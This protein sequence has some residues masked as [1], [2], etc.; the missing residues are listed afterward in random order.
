MGVEIASTLA[1]LHHPTA[2]EPTEYVLVIAAPSYRLGVRTFLSTVK[3]SKYCCARNL[4]Y[5]Q[6]RFAWALDILTC[7]CVSILVRSFESAGFHENYSAPDTRRNVPFASRVA[8]KRLTGAMLRSSSKTPGALHVEETADDF[9]MPMDGWR[10]QSCLVATV[11]A[12]MRHQSGKARNVASTFFAR[13]VPE[14][15]GRGGGNVRLIE[16]FDEHFLTPP[17]AICRTTTFGDSRGHD[18]KEFDL[19]IALGARR[20]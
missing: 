6:D 17:R 9:F 7:T 4:S 3:P 11:P 12:E 20:R 16:A 8:H 14:F 18:P 5:Q 10:P 2:G 15:G 19:H 1:H 13:S